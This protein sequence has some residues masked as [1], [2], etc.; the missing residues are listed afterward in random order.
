MI[1]K[2]YNESL[3]KKDYSAKELLK[4]IFELEEEIDLGSVSL[5]HEFPLYPLETEDTASKAHI[6]FVSSKYG[7]I[8]F[9]CINFINKIEINEFS[10]KLEQIDS[11]LYS[12]ILRDAKRL[13]KGNR[14][15]IIEITSA[16]FFLN[17][18]NKL[19]NEKLNYKYIQNKTELKNLILNNKKEELTA[20]QLTDLISTIEGAKGISKPIKRK[21]KIKNS[22]G[23]ILEAIETDTFEFDKEQK[24]A[25][26]FTID[27]AQRIR[28]LAGSGK[29]VILCMKTA[30]IHLQNSE[31]KILYTYFT[32]A[33]F[34]YIKHLIT[35][36]YR[37]FAE[38]DP[39]WNKINIMHAWGG[40][41]IEG[42]YFNAC[43]YNN[44]RPLTF[45]Q[46][47]QNSDN[48][49]DYICTDIIK[50]NLNE[51]YDYALLDE[52]QDFPKSFYKLCRKITRKNRVIWAYDDFQ[53]I[54]DIKLQNE[55]ET[56]G[57]NKQGEYYINFSK[58]NNDLQDL[59]LFKCYRNPRKLLLTAFAIGLG[60]YNKINN[61]QKVIQR[62][63]NNEHWESLGFK[64]EKGNS[65]TG[66]EMIIS[67]PKINSTELK[68]KYLEDAIVKIEVCENL[69]AEC[70]FIV[71]EIKQDI[72]QELNPEDISIICLDDRNTTTYFEAIANYLD[73]EKIKYW[74]L[75]KAPNSNKIFNVKNHVTLSTIYKA[76]GNESGSVYLLGIDSVFLQ[77]N[78]EI[79]RNKL[80]TA[81][82][83]SK[84]WVTLTGV[85]DSVK[86]CK[87][88]FEE[89]E[90]NKYKLIFKQPSEQE[91]KMIKQDINK[92]QALMNTLE[93]QAIAIS[94]T[95]GKPIEEIKQT[96]KK[97]FYDK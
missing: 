58:K 65:E 49:F 67:R 59:V 96:L 26:L 11:I 7:V 87:Q 30:L 93:R 18:K 48:P 16:F 46:A 4:I 33:L 6:L 68:N 14:N 34:D 90:K 28:G 55:K 42:V 35:R 21:I 57:K 3:V 62:L 25:A 70:K 38:R 82:T 51:Q 22:K 17:Y 36:F 52:A 88:E 40:R 39:D 60:I 23:A 74:N 76:K 69:E 84:A 83:R 44:Y 43:I 85:G 37:Q 19:N 63:E 97:E 45:H 64:V 2:N 29:T 95:S 71:S 61:K 91:V 56:F 20:K 92:K 15:L 53:N 5:Y 8:I 9:Q 79:N 41:T 32:K 47:R 80:F 75:Q 89:L 24:R 77:K 31:A 54:L 1:E 27:G 13:K 94:K 50:N 86:L 12:K 66:C 10:D 73:N 72:E 81:M 78:D